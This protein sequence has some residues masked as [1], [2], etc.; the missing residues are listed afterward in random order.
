M[1]VGP[2]NKNLGFVFASFLSS[3][4]FS[5]H[6]FL[7]RFIKASVCD[8]REVR[9]DLVLY[10]TSVF[11]NLLFIIGPYGAFVGHFPFPASHPLCSHHEILIPQTFCVSVCMLHVGL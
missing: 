8:R 7:L 4:Y 9:Q 5:S 11:L 10:D 3:F 6:S 2:N 1:S